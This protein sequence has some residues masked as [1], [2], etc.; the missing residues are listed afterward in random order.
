MTSLVITPGGVPDTSTG[1]RFGGW[2]LTTTPLNLQLDMYSMETRLS[3]LFSYYLS[4]HSYYS[5]FKTF[6]FV[7][8]DEKI[9]C[10]RYHFGCLCIQKLLRH[11]YCSCTCEHKIAPRLPS[12]VGEAVSIRE[13]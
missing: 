3:S 2:G 7:I 12:N 4:K 11:S 13:G 8:L 10:S 6:V 5:S 1:G 9:Y